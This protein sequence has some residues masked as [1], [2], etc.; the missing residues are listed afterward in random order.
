MPSTP[1][2]EFLRARRAQVT[3][4]AA[5]VATY[6]PRRVPGLRREEVATLAGMSVDYYVRL[7]QGRERRPSAQVLDAIGQVLQ[8]DDDAREHLF[9]LAGLTPG[10]ERTARPERV[11]TELDR[12]LDT[13]PD[14]PA[15]VLGRAYDVLAG[16]DLA[17]ALFDGFRQ[18]PNLLLKMFL[19][20]GARSFY[21]DWEQVARYT[22]AGFRLLEGRWPNDPR[23]REV[24]AELSR[25]SPEFVEMWQRHEARGQRL[26][27]K[28]FHHPEVG[29]L[30]LRISAFDVRSAPGQELIVYRAEPGSRSAEALALLGSLSA[31]RVRA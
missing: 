23:I 30:T 27:S 8:L 16:N 31:T 15:L 5:G 6:G 21:L 9:R 10:A 29:D 3:P 2:G 1:L 14:T 11:D 20:P 7:E 18:G 19:D 13:W 12:L 28:R 24:V 26:A 4:E 25:R 22:V 17:Y